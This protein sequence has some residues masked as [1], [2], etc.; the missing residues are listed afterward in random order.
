MK[1]ITRIK[2]KAEVIY[3][4]SLALNNLFQYLPHLP[5]MIMVMMMVMFV[6]L[7]LLLW[8]VLSLYTSYRQVKGNTIVSISIVV[9]YIFFR[10]K[11]HKTY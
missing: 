7:Q 1:P 5:F 10:F 3:I 9:P 6:S 2:C 4:F 11:E 8:T